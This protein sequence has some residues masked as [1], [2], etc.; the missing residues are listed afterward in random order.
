[1]PTDL[2]SSDSARTT[3]AC[4]VSTT[5]IRNSPLVDD[6]AFIIAHQANTQKLAKTVQHRH[7]EFHT[8]M[9]IS[10]KF[11]AGVTAATDRKRKVSA[12]L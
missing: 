3:S 11:V 12:E 9:D 8:A 4:C 5:K 10:A 1:M 6:R 2:S 7:P